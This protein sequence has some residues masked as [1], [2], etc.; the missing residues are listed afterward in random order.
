M[1]C[2]IDMQEKLKYGDLVE[3]ELAHVAITHTK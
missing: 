3:L 2:Y 1:Y